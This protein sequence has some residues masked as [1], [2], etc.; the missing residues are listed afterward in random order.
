MKRKII[1]LTS[2]LAFSLNVFAPTIFA[3]NLITDSNII[4]SENNVNTNESENK[5]NQ[6]NVENNESKNKI[7]DNSN[8][9]SSNNIEKENTVDKEITTNVDD[10][11]DS[12][13]SDINKEETTEKNIVF[14]N[15]NVEN[16]TNETNTDIA[17]EKIPNTSKSQ[18]AYIPDENLK[19]ALNSTLGKGY[20]TTD[21]TISELQ[22]IT[23]LIYNDKNGSRIN[24]ISDLTGLEHCTNLTELNL[25]SNNIKD[26]SKLSKLTKLNSLMLGWNRGITDISPLS[27][28]TYL[29]TLDLEGNQISDIGALRGLINLMDLNLILNKIS[30]I[31]PLK[32][33]Q[34]VRALVNNQKLTA[35]DVKSIGPKAEVYNIVKDLDGNFV[36]IT[37]HEEGHTYD[38]STHKVTFNEITQT[39]NQSYNFNKSFK[40]VNFV[41]ITSHGEDYTYDS[42]THKVTFNEITQTGNQSY[43]FNKSFKNVNSYVNFSGTVAQNILYDQIIEI[44]DP[45]F[46][47]CLNRNIYK[48]NNTSKDNADITLSQLEG[49]ESIVRYN[50]SN[51][52]NI[53]GVEYCKNLIGFRLQ[54]ENISDIS[55]L[56]G[57]TK[58]NT[59]QL[60]NNKIS[61]ISPLS[62]L[63]NL[64][65]LYLSDNNI[66]DISPLSGLT[67]LTTLFINN[68]KIFYL[69]SL[70]NFKA[71]S[72][73]I[74]MKNQSVTLEKTVVDDGSVKIINPVTFPEFY[75]GNPNVSISH[76][77]SIEYVKEGNKLNLSSLSDSINEFTINESATINNTNI[78]GTYS[79]NIALPVEHVSTIKVDLPTSMTF[80]VVTNTVDSEPIFATADYTINNRGKKPVSIT[81]SYTVTSPGGIDLVESISKKDISRDDNIKIAVK[82]KDLS[83]NEDILSV[84]N[85]KTGTQFSVEAESNIKLRLEP[86]TNGMADAKKEQLSDTKTT[87]G[88]MT[89]IISN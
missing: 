63:P 10:N 56:S 28:L 70:D 32:N 19:K 31:S 45:N 41:E 64:S 62:N 34:N 87:S 15:P 71:N 79:V 76:S 68:N 44:P 16:Q 20:I 36:E 66:S 51:I 30:D 50:V 33:L 11:I 1:I 85:G 35:E 7:S 27:G 73:N 69:S 58:L 37:S 74:T 3:Q 49:L 24:P 17:N 5:T 12:S 47:I 26:I 46:K 88:K 39:D 13:N 83:T 2:I 55:L 75:E 48:T 8:N 21:I 81:P 22:N 67:N 43:N 89:F 60:N 54:S 53:K 14:N 18:Y 38:S 6:E 57:L 29:K 84:V 61:N 78:N 4:G 25:D 52:K 42:S 72:L 65:I 80:N 23:S 40:N 86:G 59:I 77:G 9:K 82:L